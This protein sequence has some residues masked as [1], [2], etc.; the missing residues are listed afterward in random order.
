MSELQQLQAFLKGEV[1]RVRGEIESA[2]GKGPHLVSILADGVLIERRALRESG[3]HGAR[4]GVDTLRISF[5]VACRKH[6]RPYRAAA[7]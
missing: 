4:T 6:L 2:L 3:M 5:S 1:E 7:E